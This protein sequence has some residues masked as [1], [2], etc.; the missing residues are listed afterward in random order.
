MLPVQSAPTASIGGNTLGA[1]L[2]LILTSKQPRVFIHRCLSDRV[3]LVPGTFFF[4]YDICCL[5]NKSYISDL[6][7]MQGD[8]HKKRYIFMNLQQIKED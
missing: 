6:E 4:K 2:S 1:Q 3:L 7:V 8:V 5:V